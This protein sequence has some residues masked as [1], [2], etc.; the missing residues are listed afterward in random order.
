MTPIIS[1]LSDKDRIVGLVIGSKIDLRALRFGLD[2][3]GIKRDRY[4]FHEKITQ[5]LM[6]SKD[7]IFL[8]AGNLKTSMPVTLK[9]YRLNNTDY[10]I[11]S[12]NG[13]SLLNFKPEILRGGYVKEKNAIWVEV[14]NLSQLGLVIIDGH[15]IKLTPNNRG[16]ATFGV[17]DFINKKNKGIYMYL[18][19][20]LTD[21]ESKP[22]KISF[23]K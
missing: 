20:P 5:N 15:Q 1:D 11:S 3:F 7:P 14:H 22:F 13:Y 6:N 2:F 8:I 4:V 10:T 21:L 17:L 23:A 12:L 19:D 18:F 16:I 9:E